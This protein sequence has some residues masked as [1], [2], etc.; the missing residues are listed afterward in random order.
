MNSIVILLS[1]F[2]LSWKNDFLRSSQRWRGRWLLLALA[3][4]FWGGI[5]YVVR[6]VLLY[7]QYVDDLGPSFPYHLLL[8]SL[9]TVLSMLLFSNLITLLPNFFL[10]RDLDLLLSTSVSTG[11]FYYS[12]VIP[13]LL[14]PSGMLLFFSLP[15]FAS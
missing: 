5:Y 6:R 3:I 10:A 9:L 13:P 12:R 15:I 14:N 11:P 7:L 2:W 8:I 1:P 4:A